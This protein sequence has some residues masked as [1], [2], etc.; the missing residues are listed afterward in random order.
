MSN[1]PRPARWALCAGDVTVPGVPGPI[2]F[3][4]REE[5]TIV[6]GS[7]GLAVVDP[8]EPENQIVVPFP[9][10]THRVVATC[11]ARPGGDEPELAYI[12][13]VASGARERERVPA[14]ARDGHS[15]DR[16]SSAIGT[17]A[18]WFIG[19]ADAEIASLWRNAETHS[20]SENAWYER[21]VDDFG[22]RLSAAPVELPSPH[23]GEVWMVR[24]QFAYVVRGIADDGTTVAVH[25]DVNYDWA[26]ALDR[27]PHT[28]ESPAELKELAARAAARK[29]RLALWIL[30]G[31]VVLTSGFVVLTK[32]MGW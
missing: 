23:R 18:G 27:I 31:L 12:S 16:L 17:L 29:E 5:G 15:D 10:G 7:A 11:V 4:L 3:V 2:P 22:D 21:V 32:V 6:I 14:V 24:Q 30:I 25:L 19:F 26:H 13:V 9:P 1:A 28:T 20:E 8:V